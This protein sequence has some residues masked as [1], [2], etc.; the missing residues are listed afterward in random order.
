MGEI[1]FIKFVVWTFIILNLCLWIN[2]AELEIDR[3]KEVNKQNLINQRFFNWQSHSYNDLRLYTQLIKKRTKLFK[4]DMHFTLGDNCINS[5]KDY[6]SNKEEFKLDIID[7]SYFKT[8]EIL[9]PCFVLTHDTPLTNVQYYDSFA[10]LKMLINPQLLKYY[11]E[12]FT[13]TALCFKNVPSDICDNAEFLNLLDLFFT[14]ANKLIKYYNLKAE[15][16]LDGDV[17]VACVK[18]RWRPWVYTWIRGQDPDE[19]ADSND[20]ETSFDRYQVLNDNENTIG[21]DISDKYHKF[22]NGDRPVQIWE[23]SNQS[24]ILF[25]AEQFK[26]V[27]NYAGYAFAINIDPIMFQ[28]YVAPV[29][30]EA[31]NNFIVEF[32]DYS[33]RKT[34][35]AVISSIYS[36]KIIFVLLYQTFN[37]TSK[38]F[39]ELSFKIYTTR[40]NHQGSTTEFKLK[41]EET[42]TEEGIDEIND[43]IFLSKE[44]F[45]GSY[46]FYLS[47][48][49]G[50]LSIYKLIVNENPFEKNPKAK[51][52]FIGSLPLSFMF[53]KVFEFNLTNSKNKV[54]LT[55][56]STS[57]LENEF[58]NS[59][60]KF[61]LLIANIS[62]S[63]Q[64]SKAHTLISFYEISIDVSIQ[65]IGFLNYYIIPFSYL[66]TIISFP[67]IKLSFDPVDNTYKGLFAAKNIINKTIVSF[68]IKLRITEGELIFNFFQNFGKGN[69]FSLSVLNTYD[70]TNKSSLLNFMIAKDDGYCYNNAK[71]NLSNEVKLCDRN[72]KINENIL[73]YAFGIIDDKAINT[74]KNNID[75]N[76]INLCYEGSIIAGSYDMG[77]SPNIQLFKNYDN[78]LQNEII[79]FI[80]THD[81]VP[82]G[83]MSTCGNSIPF[84]GIVVDSWG[85]HQ[86]DLNLK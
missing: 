48:K 40:I 34:K 2:N 32:E 18:D 23:P 64:T 22:K 61:S 76:I 4:I 19:A 28:I 62:D 49:R 67:N 11:Q 80:E 43:F 37:T 47:T 7:K 66:N 77:S 71:N 51:D 13:H 14:S 26:S 73:N 10:Y 58:K 1:Q 56:F 45:S 68:T 86:I 20:K 65:N 29:A 70:S 52:K 69:L 84:N 46:Y 24:K 15:F 81:G 59:N 54:D 60:K 55:S 41:L 74:P 39:S 30:E 17:K 85:L 21:H 38:P 35:F 27:L 42:F 53:L 78:H 72:E 50:K 31:T 3:Q 8:N 33:I 5:I 75:N 25:Y 36:N 16:I 6:S 12:N 83:I 79:S 44:K 9:N 63:H 82:G 57:Y